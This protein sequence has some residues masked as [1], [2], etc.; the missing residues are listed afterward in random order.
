MF[1]ATPHNTP[2]DTPSPLRES[3]AVAEP[4]YVL[5]EDPFVIRALIPAMR[6]STQLDVMMGYFASSSFAE[7]APGLA[8]FLRSTQAP[9]RI[10]VSPFLT[11]TDFD[12]VTRDDEYRTQLTRRLLIDDVPDEDDLAQ[13]ALEC[14]AWLI[15]RRRLIFKIAVMRS[16]L[17]HPK[18]W[19]FNDDKNRA[20]L[21]GS[22]N[23]TAAGLM[24]NR[25]QITFHATGSVQSPSTPS[26]VSERNLTPFGPE[27]TT[28][29]MSYP[30][31]TPSRGRSSR[32]TRPI[33][34]PT[35]AA[36]AHY[37][38][39]PTD[40]PRLQQ[41]T[42]FPIRPLSSFRCMSNTSRAI[43]R[44]KETLSELGRRLTVAAFSKWPPDQARRS[45]Q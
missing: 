6:S 4:L 25:E 26:T 20:A 23:L 33:I 3:L 37:G 1:E 42:G 34:C 35:R 31:T 43:S 19:L 27:A 21:H 24:R 11:E 45:P 36:S 14:L 18:V 15:D 41:K 38:A 17:F 40:S 44:T 10:V 9:L 13:H 2:T 39:K 7:I 29:A 28:T 8:T 32:S 16:A 12:T 30:S 5:P 22:T